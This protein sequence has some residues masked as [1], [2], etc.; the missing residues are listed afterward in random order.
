MRSLNLWRLSNLSKLKLSSNKGKR[1]KWFILIEVVSIMV[2][3]TRWDATLDHL[4][5]TFR[6]VALMLSIQ[7]L[8]LFN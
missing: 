1:S 5:G 7:C 2:D 3:M 6:N 8:V 4:R